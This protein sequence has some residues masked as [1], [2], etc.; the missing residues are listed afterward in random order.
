VFFFFI[1]EL[2]PFSDEGCGGVGSVGLGD[3]W[4]GF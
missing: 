1:D 3:T 2:F 4:D